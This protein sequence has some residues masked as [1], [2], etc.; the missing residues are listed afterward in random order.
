MSSYVFWK[1]S[2]WHH[3]NAVPQVNCSMWL[4]HWQQ[5]SCHHRLSVCA[6]Q[7]AGTRWL[8]ADVNGWSSTC[9]TQ[10]DILEPD[11][12]RGRSKPDCR[13]IGSVTI[14][15]LAIE[16]DDQSCLHCVIVSTDVMSDHIGQSCSDWDVVVQIW[17]QVKLSHANASVCEIGAIIGHMWNDLDET[18]KK[19]YNDNYALEKVT[20]HNSLL[21]FCNVGY[22]TCSLSVLNK[23]VS[24]VLLIQ[25]K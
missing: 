3:L 10:T 12:W 4:V 6:E 20:A 7:T 8:I 9:S 17:P 23:V 25:Q 11:V 16:A 2:P 14:V 18:E 22:I 15:W 1:S 21:V 13:I 19:R 5:N 24:L